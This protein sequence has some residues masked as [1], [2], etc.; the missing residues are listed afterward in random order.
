M[1]ESIDL[2]FYANKSQVW[3]RF[4]LKSDGAVEEDG[5]YFD[6]FSI[7]GYSRFMIGDIN[8]DNYLNIYDLVMLIELAVLDI[9]LPDDLFP[10][11][12]INIDNN[13]DYDDIISLIYLI[14]NTY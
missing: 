8:R 6:N 1:N 5:F 4:L 2:S 10:L 11:A 3:I 14:M 9:T 12:D 7:N 13:I